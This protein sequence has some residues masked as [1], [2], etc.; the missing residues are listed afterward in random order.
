MLANVTTPA[1]AD[2]PYR[3]RVKSTS[4]TLT[5]DCAIRATCIDMSTRARVG[6]RSRA[7]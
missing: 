6:T 5:I 4:A 7:R 1:N 2:E 3:S